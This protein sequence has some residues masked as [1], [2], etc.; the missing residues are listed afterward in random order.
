MIIIWLRDYEKVLSSNR[1][2]IDT[3]PRSAD[4]SNN[5]VKRG[6]PTRVKKK[7][8]AIATK[9]DVARQLLSVGTD[10]D[11]YDPHAPERQERLAYRRKLEE[12]KPKNTT[13]KLQVSFKKLTTFDEF[14]DAEGKKE[15]CFATGDMD[16]FHTLYPHIEHHL[17]SPTKKKASTVQQRPK[18]SPMVRTK[19]LPYQLTCVAEDDL[20]SK[21]ERPPAQFELDVAQKAVTMWKSALTTLRLRG[22]EILYED[23]SKLS[24]KWKKS[25]RLRDLVMYIS[26]L[27]GLKSDDPKMTQRSVFRELYSL[28]KFFREVSESF[29]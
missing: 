29:S 12:N 20:V 24:K 11:E 17:V 27:L 28:L 18:S 9:V 25:E 7:K 1:K 2:S 15:Q 14:K 26:I 4:I 8:D 22:K 19:V 16:L 3:R 23:L 13:N 10:M 21:P 6:R 5:R